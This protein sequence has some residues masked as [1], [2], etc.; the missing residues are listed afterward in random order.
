LDDSVGLLAVERAY[1]RSIERAGLEGLD[2]SEEEDSS[3]DDSSEVDS[4]EEDGG[5]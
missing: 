1:I 4:K 3:E 2:D 5:G